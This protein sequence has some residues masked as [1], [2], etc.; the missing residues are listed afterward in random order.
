MDRLDDL[1]LHVGFGSASITDS[2]PYNTIQ[3]PEHSIETLEGSENENHYFQGLFGWWMCLKYYW[4]FKS[5]KFRIGARKL[6]IGEILRKVI[7][8]N[9]RWCKDWVENGS[10]WFLVSACGCVWL[11]VGGCKGHEG[12]A[13]SHQRYNT[14]SSLLVNG[15][16]T[17][18]QQVITDCITHFYTGLYSEES[19][20][21]PKLDNLAFS[22]IS[23]E[24]AAWLERP[25]GEEEVVGVLKAF[26]GD[27]APGPDGFPMAFFQACWDVVHTEVMESIKYFHEVAAMEVKDF[28]PISLVGGMYKIFA[29][30]LASR[31]KMVLHKIISPS[32]NAFVQ[33]RQILDSV[34]I[35][36]EVLDSRLKV[37]LSRVLCKLDIE[38]AYDHVKWEFLIYL[39]RRC[40]FPGK[41]C[42]WI[43]FCI[44]T[45]QFSILVNGSPQGFFASSRGLRQGDP[46]SPLLFVIV[47]ETLSRLMDRATIWWLY[48]WFCSRLGAESQHAKSEMVPVGVV[49][50]LESLVELM[51]CNIRSHPL[52]YL[53][54]PLGA[55]FNLKTIWNIVIEKMEKMLGGW[56]RLYLSKGGKLTLLRSTL[57]SIP[58]YFLSL[59]HLP[60]GVA[61]RL[62]KIQRDF[63]WSGLGEAQK[64]H[65]VNWTQICKPVQGGGLGVK[66]LRWFNKA[67]RGKWLWRYGTERDAYWRKVVEIKYGMLTGGKLWRLSMGVCGV[68]GV[69]KRV[70]ARMRVDI[71]DKVQF[72]HDTW[73]SDLPLKVLYPELF[74][75]A[76]DKD[77]S[78]AALMSFSN[79][80]L[81]WDVSFSRNVQD[82]ELESLVAF[83]EL[84]YSR[85]LDGTG[86]D[87]LC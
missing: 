75:I 44:S 36:N 20:W 50:N 49:P 18:D 21:R 13:N 69:L 19:G 73:C 5:G 64:M 59:F 24:D 26:N 56:K 66:N 47:M 85:T 9:D 23:A 12:V 22:M 30:L 61:T 67:L 52:T 62:E 58:T 55:N 70:M 42:N 78:V 37:G 48:F 34:L 81:H 57:S 16:L 87:Q 82:W 79:G 80:T 11:W 4:V 31:L 72:W 29:K 6:K 51:G 41:W 39:L 60:A 40:G 2:G 43:W 71:G 45:V 8:V 25:F 27:K 65:L 54:L 32:Q 76:R 1:V 53:G 84:I 77:T 28:R 7:Y 35:A 14:M 86:Q 15:A 83:M 38:K 10:A 17:T 33:G 3:A 68:G 46:L 63:L 74:S